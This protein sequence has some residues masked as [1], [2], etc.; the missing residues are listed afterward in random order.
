MPAEG[1]TMTSIHHDLDLISQ[2]DGWSTMTWRH[3]TPA[4]VEVHRAPRR[5]LLAAGRHRFERFVS[6]AQSWH[7]RARQRR[8]L[9][10][11][12]AH[13]LRDIGLDRVS[14]EAEARKPFW[15]P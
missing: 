12:S 14:A 13:M 4:L 8:A 1:V 5:S 10:H 6:L 15:R 3:Q 11:L 7:E 9:R 2:V